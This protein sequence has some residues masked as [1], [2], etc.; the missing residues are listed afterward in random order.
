VIQAISE[1]FRPAAAP[2]LLGV[3]TEASTEQARIQIYTLYLLI[4]KIVESKTK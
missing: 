2:F 4:A 3:V 1:N